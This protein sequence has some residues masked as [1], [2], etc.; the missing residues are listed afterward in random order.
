MSNIDAEV[1]FLHGDK[2]KWVPI[3]NVAYGLTKMINAKSKVTDT[4]HDAG[5][6]IQLTDKQRIIKVLT[7]LY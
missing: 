1:I 2:D 3:E 7:A 4:I 5:H 6:M